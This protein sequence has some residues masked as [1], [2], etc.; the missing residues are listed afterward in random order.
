[1][2]TP[3]LPSGPGGFTEASEVKAFRVA[4]TP[5]PTL[6]LHL[7]LENKGELFFGIGRAQLLFSIQQQGSLRKAAKAL[8]MSYRAAWG[9]IKLTEERIGK[10]IVETGE[11]KKLHLTK[12]A[13]KI[14]DE[15]EK[16]EKDV[17]GFLHAR[18]STFIV[19]KDPP[20]KSDEKK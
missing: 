1:M 15:F 19:L 9:K 7:W 4:P 6:R 8:G 14:L 20:T 18:R 3:T 13:K 11:D 10:K 16:L 2:T 12:D 17:D 5:R